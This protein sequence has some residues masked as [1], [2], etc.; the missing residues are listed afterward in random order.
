MPKNLK[1]LSESEIRL[2][3]GHR[4]CPGCGEPIAVRQI[5]MGT[6]DPVIVVSATGCTEV[7]T[8]IFPY[9]A[10]ACP[11]LHIAF[12]NAGA[13]VSG[14]EAMYKAKMSQAAKGM[15]LP[16]YIPADKPYKFVAF[17]G[18][19][20]TYD[21]GL[22][23]LSG[24]VERRQQFL[25]V[26]LNNEAYMNTG[27]QRSSATPMGM[28]TTTS[29][30]GVVS[31]GKAVNRKDLTEIMVAHEMPYVAQCGVTRWRDLV[32]CAEKAFAI[33]G[34]T[35]INCLTPCPLGWIHDSGK[36][37]ELGQMATDCCIWPLYEVMDGVYKLNYRPKEKQPLDEYLK[38]QGRF[39]HLFKGEEGAAMRVAMQEW[40]DMKWAQLLK[41]CGQDE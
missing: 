31:A 15:P 28:H 12:E 22:Q 9:T 30:S 35:F 21:I 41:K 13:A 16:D 2:T 11:W 36:T 5:L 38:A 37:L 1:Q 27:V 34:P 23:S 19:G 17:A 8:T 26:C 40:V 33:D 20:A 10:W 39:R 14:V 18:D 3:A 24:A 32:G 6:E 7:S 29:Q 25:Y 4:L